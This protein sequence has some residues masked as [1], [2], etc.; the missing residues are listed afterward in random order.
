MKFKDIM[1]SIGSGLKTGYTWVEK[2][3]DKL[4]RKITQSDKTFDDIL[5][6]KV[7]QPVL[8]KT[9]T[10]FVA[11]VNNIKNTAVNT[12]NKVK[13]IRNPDKKEIDKNI[14]NIIT[15]ETL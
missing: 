4:E 8:A 3:T 15:G 13:N 5:K 2:N 1:K 11:A 10:K 14:N 9:P 6:E 7:Y 12:T